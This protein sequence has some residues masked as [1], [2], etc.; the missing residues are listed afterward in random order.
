MAIL[1][2]VSIVLLMIAI[3]VVVVNRDVLFNRGAARR[4]IPEAPLPFLIF[5]VSA[6]GPVII[7]AGVGVS[8]IVEERAESQGLPTEPAHVAA[9][10]AV[11]EPA[12]AAERLEES[13]VTRSA[14]V[15]D[16]SSATPEPARRWPRALSEAEYEDSVAADATMVFNRP[17]DEAVQILPGRLRVLS[18]ENIGEELRLFNRLG[19]PPR[20]V[21]GRDSGPLHQH[22]TLRS[23]TV[24]R[25]H[26]RIELVNGCWSITNLSTTNPVL[27][28]DRVLAKDGATRTLSDGDRIELGEVAL[29]F[30]AS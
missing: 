23:P 17:M 18:G 29:R 28:N 6:D 3:P 24:S 11:A 14:T 25:R 4:E 20:I 1:V 19:D 26:A 9:V 27:V 7:P 13:P 2:L 8:G 5:P 22:I 21:V 30:L 16:D 12:K 15:A 10:A